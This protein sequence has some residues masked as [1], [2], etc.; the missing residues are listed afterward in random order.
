MQGFLYLDLPG[1]FQL[2]CSHI[3]YGKMTLYNTLD[4]CLIVEFF[5]FCSHAKFSVKTQSWQSDTEKMS[6]EEW[7]IVHMAIFHPVSVKKT[8]HADCLGL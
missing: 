4:Q 3:D 5:R 7:R 2:A 6:D 1:T 8:W